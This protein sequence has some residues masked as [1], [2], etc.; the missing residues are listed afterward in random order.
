MTKPELDFLG[1]GERVATGVRDINA[2]AW[3]QS[4]KALYGVMYGRDGTNKFWPALVSP[5]D[6]ASVSDEMFKISVG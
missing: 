2:V 4:Q 1:D 6:D 5:A 3:S